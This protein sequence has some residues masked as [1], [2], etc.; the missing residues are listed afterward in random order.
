MQTIL[1]KIVSK[2][3]GLKSVNFSVNEN[4]IFINLPKQFIRLMV[5][6]GNRKLTE[7]EKNTAKS[8]LSN[9]SDISDYYFIIITDKDYLEIFELIE[10]KRFKLLQE[11]CKASHKK[12][13]LL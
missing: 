6:T 8:F 13:K 10:S 9:F 2:F 4:R 3:K 11:Y 7:E 5:L 1:E 12:Y